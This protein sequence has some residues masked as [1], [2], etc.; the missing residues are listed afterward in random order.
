MPR[1]PR[2][3]EKA[4]RSTSYL[5]ETPKG[6]IVM[7]IGELCPELA[8]LMREHGAK[9]AAYLTAV[10]PRSERLSDEENM[11]R[12]AELD[13]VLDRG[14]FTYFKGRAV[15]DRGDWPVEESRLVL[16]IKEHHAQYLGYLLDQRAILLIRT[17][18]G[19]PAIRLCK[20]PSRPKANTASV[21]HY[22]EIREDLYP[23]HSRLLW[24]SSLVAMLFLLLA[25]CYAVPE[26]SAKILAIFMWLGFLVVVLLAG[27]PLLRKERLR[28]PFT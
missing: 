11:G 14:G 23:L 19:L 12:L 10:N 18:A 9:T 3:L 28:L 26:E 16:G 13:V 20:L 8:E 21:Q 22:Q 15:A 17:L 27:I 1:L 5:A 25:I 24:G 2:D 6:K 4:Y 7:R